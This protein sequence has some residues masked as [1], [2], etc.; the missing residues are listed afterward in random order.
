MAF[1]SNTST[2]ISFAEYEDVLAMDQRVFEAN[3]GLVDTEVE[4]QLIRSTERILYLIR[5]T[6]WWKQYYIRQTGSNSDVVA[7]N[8]R[9]VVPVPNP[10]KIL[11]RRTDFTDL[12]V[13]YGLYEY[14]LPKIAD[15]SNQDN[16]EVRKL[17]LYKEKFNKLFDELIQDGS[18]YDFN[19]DLTVSLNEKMPTVT[20]LVRVR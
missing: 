1:I 6:D 20:N 7:F 9:V 16:A 19:D 13:Y 15:F 4:D 8:G 18:W 3:E 5:N 2:V 17:G 14:I 12:C 10:K 11:A